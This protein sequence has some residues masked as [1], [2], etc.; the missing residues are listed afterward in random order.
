MMR[1]HLASNH[2]SGGAHVDR[3]RVRATVAWQPPRDEGG[4]SLASACRM[5]AESSVT[6]GAPSY[7]L[8]LDRSATVSTCLV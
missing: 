1:H 5:G 8:A 4:D 2:M 3:M 6:P 7:P